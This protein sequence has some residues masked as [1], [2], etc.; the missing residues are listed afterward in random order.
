MRVSRVWGGT[1]LSDSSHPG[2]V[3]S[4]Q[5][6]AKEIE[7]RNINVLELKGALFTLK[8]LCTDV[9]NKT[10]DLKVDNRT[11]VAAVRKMGSKS[12]KCDLIAREIWE[13]AIESKN[14]ITVSHIAGVENVCA[15]RESRKA[16]KVEIEWGLSRKCFDMIGDK[17]KFAPQVDLFTARLN[18]KVKPFYAWKPDPEADGCDAF[19]KCCESKI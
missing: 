8:S 1:R 17:F 12:R 3:A 9:S 14:W 11:A 6:S 2:A 7:S 19:T 13:W 15:D 16:H 5:W 4:G 10:I 18:Y